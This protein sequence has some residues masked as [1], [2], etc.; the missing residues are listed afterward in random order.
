MGFIDKLKEAAQEGV[1][2]AKKGAAA[3]KD[4]VED[5][6]LRRKADDLAKQVGYL[7]VKGDVSGEEATRLVS[8][9]KDLE[10]QLAAAAETT[11]PDDDA[12]AS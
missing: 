5:V 8:E 9:I 7:V 3:A 12:S 11:E 4:K 6:Q 1:E 10:A 2:V